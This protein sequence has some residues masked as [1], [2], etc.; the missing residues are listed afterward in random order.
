MAHCENIIV[1]CMDPRIQHTMRKLRRQLNVA[2]GHYDLIAVAGGAGNFE[3]LEKHLELSKRLHASTTAILTV[4]DDCGAGAKPEDLK[5]A[6]EIAR[7]LGFS[8]RAFVVHLERPL[9]E[10][11]QV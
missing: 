6:S 11:V 3:Q 8:V 9:L 4:H 10:E 2:D 1:H 7:K 5:K